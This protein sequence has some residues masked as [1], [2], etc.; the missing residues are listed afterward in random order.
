MEDIKT[1]LRKAK[2]DIIKAIIHYSL[3]G[4]KKDLELINKHVSDE[5]F[6]RCF[7]EYVKNGCKI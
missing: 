5:D 7:V 3:L 1:M 4:S 2:P 6:K